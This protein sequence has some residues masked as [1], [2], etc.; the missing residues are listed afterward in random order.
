MPMSQEKKI[1][2]KIDDNGAD[3]QLC[4]M[5]KPHTPCTKHSSEPVNIELDYAMQTQIIFIFL[6]WSDTQHGTARY[7]TPYTLSIS[8]E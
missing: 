2:M 5:R 6:I 3:I 4:H 8:F 1:K 7:G